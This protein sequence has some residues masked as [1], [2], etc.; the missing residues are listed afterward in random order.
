MEK[1]NHMMKAKKNM[2]KMIMKKMLIM[3]TVNNIFLKTN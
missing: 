1:M 2:K 3:L